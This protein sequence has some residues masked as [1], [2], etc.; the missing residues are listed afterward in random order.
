MNMYRFFSITSF[1]F[2]LFWVH[3]CKTD[4][5]KKET[6]ELPN[7]LL[8]VSEDHGQDL[9]C[10]GN[11]VVKT[12]NIDFLASEGVRFN[13]AYT[14]YSVCSPSRSS[15]ITGLYPH[16]NGQMG[17]ASC[18]FRMYD[19]I[20]TL[21]KY[22]RETIIRDVSAKSMLILNRRS[23]GIT[24]PADYLTVLILARRTCRDMQLKQWNLFAR[25]MVIRFS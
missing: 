10:Y 5:T 23:P 1:C 24:V 11:N 7:V 20:K 4:S 15:I 9:G 21:P 12:P 6:S 13:N 18:S 3:S 22:L 16:Q 17:L 25:Q 2:L 14:T 8:I 19:G